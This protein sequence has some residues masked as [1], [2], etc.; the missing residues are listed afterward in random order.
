M[1]DPLKPAEIYPGAQSE[2]ASREQYRLGLE[3]ST[4]HDGLAPD[5][6]MA[7]MWLNVAAM[8]GNVPAREL[9]SEISQNMS[10]K[11]V[12]EAQRLAR[13]WVNTRH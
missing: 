13:E 8:N 4:G 6:I 3:H 2:A 12:A 7:H 10:R 1:S 5:Y 9:R 11:E